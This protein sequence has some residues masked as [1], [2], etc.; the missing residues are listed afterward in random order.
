MSDLTYKG[1]TFEFCDMTSYHERMR[2]VHSTVVR[3]SPSKWFPDT[4]VELRMNCDWDPASVFSCG[5]IIQM[6]DTIYLENFAWTAF[7]LEFDGE[8][9]KQD[10]PY[11]FEDWMGKSL[12]AYNY[13][14]GSDEITTMNSGVPLEKLLGLLFPQKCI[15]FN[16]YE[17]DRED[18]IIAVM[19]QLQRHGIDNETAIKI[20]EYA[21]PDV[22]GYYV[23]IPTCRDFRMQ[24]CFGPFETNRFEREV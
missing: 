5:T 13:D 23:D 22:C 20:A 18:V 19:E 10:Y 9:T 3:V 17:Q 21:Y 12:V 6:G 4:V 8:H 16:Q 2:V 24:G 14:D 15:K 7:C 1:E 11:D